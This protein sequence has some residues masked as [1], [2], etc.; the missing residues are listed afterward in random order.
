MLEHYQLNIQRI[1]DINVGKVIMFSAMMSRY[2]SGVIRPRLS[3]VF[4]MCS[5]RR[6][7]NSCCSC[8]WVSWLS[9]VEGEVTDVTSVTCIADSP[10]KL[11][12]LPTNAQ[13]KVLFTNFFSKTESTE[14]KL[15]M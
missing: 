5:A 6:K 14:T 11:L 8:P 4:V 1:D 12:L 2:S 15:K 13:K 10:V 9:A 7:L 3:M